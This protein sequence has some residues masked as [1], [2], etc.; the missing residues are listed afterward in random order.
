MRLAGAWMI[1]QTDPLT[2]LSA[3]FI[4]DSRSMTLEHLP[5][6]R[7][8]HSR[9]HLPVSL[10]HQPAVAAFIALAIGIAIDRQFNPGLTLYGI[11]WLAC[12]TL[13][14]IQKVRNGRVS[15]I[16]V[17]A[18]CCCVGAAR[19]HSFWWII[20]QDD[21]SRFAADGHRPILL[22]GR[23][24]N[25]P[26]VRYS[27]SADAT[28]S[29]AQLTDTTSCDIECQ[30]LA[31]REV[32]GRVRLTV[33]G[34]LTHVRVGDLVSVHGLFGTPE[35]SSNP[36]D[37]DY[38]DYLRRHGVR[39]VIRSSHPDAV[40]L[41]QPATRWDAGRAIDSL[42][43]QAQV[44]LERE[45]SSKVLPVA[46][47]ILLGNRDQIGDDLRRTFVESGTMHLLAIS[48]LHVGILA[49]LIWMTCRVLGLSVRASAFVLIVSIVGYA[50]VTEAR[51]PVIR[52][53]ILIAIAAVGRAAFRKTSLTNMLAIA[54]IVLLL[55]NPADLFDVGA[56]LSF[57]AVAGI[58]LANRIRP[59]PNDSNE[60]PT[61]RGRI[62]VSDHLAEW[63]QRQK[64][65][66]VQGMRM[67]V[68]IT[69]LSAPLVAKEFHIVSP[70]GMVINIGLIMLVAPILWCGYAMLFCGFLIPP[71]AP[72]FATMF[73]AGLKL[74]LQVAETGSSFSLGHRYVSGPEGWWL[75]GYLVIAV[76]PL[77]FVA[78]HDR[79]R[80]WFAAL[81]VWTLIGQAAALRST[82]PNGLRCTF[83]SVGHGLCVFIETPNGRCLLYDSGTM[84]SQH[85][86]F[87][88][89]S[90]TIWSRR[91][92]RVDA[93]VVSHA[94]IDHFNGLPELFEAMS[95]GQL[96]TT[97]TVANQPGPAAKTLIH[98]ANGADIPVEILRVGDKIRM[99]DAVAIRVLHPEPGST[100]SSDNADSLALSIEF[101]GRRILLTGDLE[102]EGL[103]QLLN[104]PPLHSNILLSPH[105]GSRAANT[106]ELAAWAR[107]QWVV[108]S[109]SRSDSIS[110]LV[111]VYADSTVLTTSIHGAITFEIRPDGT[112]QL[113][114]FHPDRPLIAQPQRRSAH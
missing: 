9:I 36:G 42:R 30:Q 23:I 44:I 102:A 13:L 110:H 99:D 56:R 63:F 70:I 50:M 103:Q 47:A 3:G 57:L 19:H 84:G 90:G 12:C 41:L 17:L 45:L 96:L 25:R 100:P 6:H 38:S 24:L 91:R 51:P 11:V 60:R 33:A 68:G 20:P 43:R 27:E 80:C 32:S 5:P 86:A 40:S 52:A 98:A 82:A 1:R 69:L 101:A 4:D 15:A 73:E 106:P 16:V 89:A 94:D 87:D 93:V 76:L 49:V 97:R 28:L 62:S 108:A 61:R 14:L 111:P 21:V 46:S 78:R 72:C 75:A 71:L 66:V 67:M 7:D 79:L 48:G 92:N 85:R 77:G 54:G 64:T 18:I 34:H 37:F 31:N 95:V 59:I 104:Q 81:L 8:F 39:C 58:A 74:I 2:A 107:P 113:E 112:I 88:A 114:T 26:A 29:R 10:P 65:N 35:P 55:W 109:C 105:H 22:V 83:I 53:S